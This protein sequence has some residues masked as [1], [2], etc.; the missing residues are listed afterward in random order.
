M[1]FLKPLIIILLSISLVATN[2]IDCEPMSECM[3]HCNFV[4][5]GGFVT[6][7]TIYSGVMGVCDNYSRCKC[8]HMPSNRV[9]GY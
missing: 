9:L 8:I 2:T 7:G 1:S 5:N 3:R 4:Y 6:L